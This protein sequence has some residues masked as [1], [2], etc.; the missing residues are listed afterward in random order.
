MKS[1]SARRSHLTRALSASMT[2]AMAVSATPLRSQAPVERYVITVDS[3]LSELTVKATLTV[4]SGALYMHT[5]GTGDRNYWR[6]Q[7]RGLTVADSLGRLIEVDS[8]GEGRFSLAKNYSGRAELSYTVDLG[9]ARQPFASGNQKT[10]WRVGSAVYLVTKPLFVV[11]DTADAVAREVQ[12]ILPKTYAVATP[13]ARAGM[14]AQSYRVIGVRELN[15]NSIVVGRFTMR[16]IQHGSFAMKIAFLGAL[17]AGVAPITRVLDLVLRDYVHRFGVPDRTNYLMTFYQVGVDAGEAYASSSVTTMRVAPSAVGLPMWGNTIA[18]ELF[19]LWNSSW[20]QSNSKDSTEWFSE[21]F[22]EYY[23]NRAMRAAG[24]IDRDA[25]VAKMSKHLGAYAFWQERPMF[26][27]SLVNGG[28]DK[29][30]H[31]LGLYDGGWSV[32]FV[33]DMKLRESRSPITL[34]TFM[35]ALFQRYAAAGRPFIYEDLVNM[36]DELLGAQGR[37]IF[38]RYVSGRELLPLDEAVRSLGY[39]LQLAPGA[40]EALLSPLANATNAQR[41]ARLRYLL[42]N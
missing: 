7:V 16:T 35:R 37:A 8:V 24:L 41:M 2:A 5:R 18:H 20:L 14:A 36:A 17:E 25:Y 32:A 40:G 38:D 28:R 42:G 21:G 9:F 13:W 19:H 27:T 30:L 26:N 11:T 10:G 23:A 12:F 33:L 3:A 15:H 29:T 1:P 22:T 31:T 39:D 6:R 4:R 34:D